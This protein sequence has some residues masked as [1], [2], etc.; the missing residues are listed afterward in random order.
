M[1]TAVG[2]TERTYI[3]FL[4]LCQ[5]FLLHGAPIT[6]LMHPSWFEKVKKK[7]GRKTR[8]KTRNRTPS[9]NLGSDNS[10]ELRPVYNTIT[11]LCSGLSYSLSEQAGVSLM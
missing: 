4:L 7:I 10:H 3:L 2:D 5:L 1:V 9:S 6:M 8:G 11:Y